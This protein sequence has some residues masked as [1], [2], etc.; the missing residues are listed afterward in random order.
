V[1]ETKDNCEG[2]KGEI[3]Q[4]GLIEKKRGYMM[5]MELG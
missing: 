2:M 4:E 5:K 1:R 3:D